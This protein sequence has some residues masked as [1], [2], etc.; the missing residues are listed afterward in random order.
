MRRPG[1]ASAAGRRKARP[2]DC[3][4]RSSGR[5]GRASRRLPR[6]GRGSP[7]LPGGGSSRR[8]R[9]TAWGLRRG[10][11]AASTGA[12]PAVAVVT[13]RLQS[14]SRRGAVGP[15]AGLSAAHSGPLPPLHG[16]ERAMGSAR[17][18]RRQPLCRMSQAAG[19]SPTPD[20]KESQMSS[21]RLLATRAKGIAP[22]PAPSRKKW[23]PITRSVWKRPGM[24]DTSWSDVSPVRT[25]SAW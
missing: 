5:R 16:G 15:A 20:P 18:C 3:A 4:R 22:E 6:R 14:E 19:E 17:G 9:G 24:G 8:R 21:A 25:R 7:R 12:A 13:M 11:R 23:M 10:M 2:T 1:S